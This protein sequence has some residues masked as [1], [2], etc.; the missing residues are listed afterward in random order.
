M[1]ESTTIITYYYL[2]KS[3][4]PPSTYIQWI[5]N[6]LQIDTPMIIFTNTDTY[7]K[8]FNRLKVK[9]KK[10]KFYILEIEQFLV[11]KYYDYFKKDHIRDKERTRHSP[12]LYMIWN[13]KLD[14]I[15][16]VIKEDPFKTEWFFACD[17][18]CMRDPTIMDKY[19][20]WPKMNKLEKHKNKVSLLSV[21]PFTNKELKIKKDEYYDFS[22]IFCRVAGGFCIG[23]KEPLLKW[24]KKFFY[25]L[26][27]MI[28]QD[29]FIGKDQNIINICYLHNKELVNLIPAKQ[30]NTSIF[31]K[32]WFLSKYLL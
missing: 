14:F 21:E 26:E 1:S 24:K 13:N 16:K 12:E 8:L 5:N 32:W 18:G 30:I 22:K 4:F 2:I 15:E 17:I 6:F 19:K 23:K 29:M 28:K 27:A 7:Q 9:D 20:N 11:F 3:K 10:I 31:S 25:T